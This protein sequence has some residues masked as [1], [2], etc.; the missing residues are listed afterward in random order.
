MKK[1]QKATEINLPRSN[2]AKCPIY[3]H[4][5]KYYVKCNKPNVGCY[6]NLMYNGEE[7]AQ[8][9]YLENKSGEKWWYQANLEG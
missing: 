1:F 3:E 7:Y 2:H 9:K 4:E 6:H 8:V 5:G